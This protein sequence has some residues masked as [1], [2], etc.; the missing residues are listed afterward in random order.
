MVKRLAEPMGT[1][2]ASIPT[3]VRLLRDEDVAILFDIHAP[4]L[5]REDRSDRLYERLLV[6]SGIRSCYVAVTPDGHPCAALWLISPADNARLKGISNGGYPMI[7]HDEMLLEG[8]FTLNQFRN[9]RIMARGIAQVLALARAAGA[10]RVI[11]FVHHDNAASLR[12]LVRTGFV[13]YAVKRERWFLFFKTLSFAA[14]SDQQGGDTRPNNSSSNE[15]VGEIPAGGKS[16]A[17]STMAGG[18]A[19]SMIEPSTSVVTP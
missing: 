3:S 1:V 6:N 13:K 14:F 18:P 17:P 5:S 10:A 2:P 7:A 15:V 9:K 19:P 11:C 12:T 4:G 16:P 8:T